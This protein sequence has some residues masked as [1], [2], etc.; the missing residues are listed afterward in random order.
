MTADH[1]RRGCMPLP[2]AAASPL[3]SGVS[4]SR[5]HPPKAVLVEHPAAA[6]RAQRSRAAAAAASAAQHACHA[7]REL[8]RLYLRPTQPARAATDTGAA[9]AVGADVRVQC[10][11]RRSRRELC[12]H[13]VAA[14]S[15]NLRRDPDPARPP[16]ARSGQQPPWP[17]SVLC[18][19]GR[20]LGTVLHIHTYV[21]IRNFQWRAHRAAKCTQLRTSSG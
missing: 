3:S 14:V 8:R 10:T 17:S 15:R 12:S 16:H 5:P 21:I 11:T 20:G 4:H 2:H 9:A 1:A 18:G 19:P 7:S 13:W 6:H